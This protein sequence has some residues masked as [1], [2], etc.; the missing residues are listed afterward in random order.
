MGTGDAILF[1]LEADRTCLLGLQEQM[2]FCRNWNL[3]SK[4]NG[5]SSK[6]TQLYQTE[7]RTYE[8][9]GNI[10]LKQYSPVNFIEFCNSLCKNVDSCERRWEMEDESQ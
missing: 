5:N 2:I 4:K 8:Q 7:L 10:L 1:S 6:S 9:I 3:T